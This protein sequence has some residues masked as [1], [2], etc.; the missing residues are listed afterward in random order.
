MKYLLLRVWGKYCIK[1]EVWIL[2]ILVDID[3]I[4]KKR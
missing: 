1:I 3:D 2:E 4:W